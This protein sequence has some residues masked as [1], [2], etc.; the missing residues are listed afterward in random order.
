MRG[1]KMS[2]CTEIR[3]DALPANPEELHRA[4]IAAYALGDY[5]RAHIYFQQLVAIQPDNYIALSNL[6]VTCRA[7][8][9]CADAREYLERALELQPDFCDAWN[10]LGAVCL[11]TDPDRALASFKRALQLVPDRVTAYNNIA[12]FYK[13]KQLF[14]E[15]VDWY[16]R[17]LAVQTDQPATWYRLAELLELLA[18][19][20][21][22]RFA[23]QQSLAAKV[24]DAVLLKK[25][26][27]V[28]VVLGSSEA[29]IAL[30]CEL[31]SRL[32]MIR[33]RGLTIERPWERGRVF[34]YP[35]YHGGNDRAFQR[36]LATLY[37]IASP[38]LTWQAPHT[39]IGR[40]STEKIRIGFISRFFYT[41]TIAKLNIGLVEQLDRTR[42]HVSVLLID[43]GIRDDM[44]SRFAA[45][46]DSFI[47]LAKDFYSIREQ[48]A[49]RELD[50]LFFTDIGMEPISYFLAFSRLAKMQCVTW[51]HPTTTGIDTID[52]FISHDH[53]ETD[54]SR[55]A[56]SERLFCLSTA[57]AC[58]C[59]ARPVL[60]NRSKSLEEYGIS[61]SGNIYF[62]PQPPFK[63]HPDFDL[64]IKGIMEHDPAGIV[65]LLRGVAVEAEKQLLARFEGSMPHCLDRIVFLDPLP[66]ADYLTM[67]GLADV[68][69]DTPHF[70]GGNSS[71]EALA[72]G[73]AVVTLPSPFLKGRLTYAW[74]RRLG[75]MDC[76]AVTPEQYVTIAVRL[77][78][79]HSA[80]KEI[81]RRIL[82]ASH[83]LF[84]DVQVVREL[85]SF[86]T[87]SLSRNNGGSA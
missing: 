34:F 66:F 5:S 35:A 10:N 61:S 37:R 44:T 77:G 72:T 78:T 8:G 79:D 68:V 22:A 84:D 2:D 60:S 50:V 28:P 23:Y 58:A 19:S 25:E 16:R 86:F 33:R 83:R 65:V 32:S 85:E 73:A 67:L 40:C 17:S 87:V 70:S 12:A 7:M 74:Y 80:R 63:L 20:E 26:T 11:A 3:C 27:L 30:R 56:Y 42:F 75:I 41:H 53:C 45:A 18:D 1:N 9:D 24:D 31:W 59:Y 29:I 54:E 62:C 71:L 47:V 13:Q 39:K 4:G 55:S 14:R 57:A 38:E 52:Y 49:A 76:V 81:S 6:G 15:A 46:A 69:L 51:G 64:L 43:A 82:Q 36:Q 21:G 48:V